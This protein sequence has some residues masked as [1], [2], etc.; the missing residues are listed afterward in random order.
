M[1]YPTIGGRSI[2]DFYRIQIN[3]TPDGYDIL[4]VLTDNIAAAPTL[5]DI[6]W[7]GTLIAGTQVDPQEDGTVKI[8]LEQYDAGKSMIQFLDK[9][10]VPSTTMAR[11]E[12]T[13]EDGTKYGG[14]S[15]TGGLVLAITY[16][17][18]NDDTTPTKVF[19]YMA[20]GRIAP[21][22]GNQKTDGTNYVMPTCEFNSISAEYDLAIPLDALRAALGDGKTI[23]HAAGGLAALVT[24]ASGTAFRRKFLALT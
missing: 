8:T 7:S 5:T 15:G 9:V 10:A 2:T 22:S 1:P 13:Y 21:T 20:I 18:Y 11:P 14:S 6:A 23:N 19:V 16:L 24:I 4:S 3:G 12:I 17:Q